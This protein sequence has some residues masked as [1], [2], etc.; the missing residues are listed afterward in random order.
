MV[1][2]YIARSCLWIC[3]L[4]I[5]ISLISIAGNCV[6]NFHIERRIL[7]NNASDVR[8]FIGLLLSI[9][10]K[11]WISMIMWVI[12]TISTMFCRSVWFRVC[13]CRLAQE[14][15]LWFMPG[16]LVSIVIS[17]NMVICR[18]CLL[19]WFACLSWSIDLSSWIYTE[20]V[21]TGLI[22]LIQFITLRVRQVITK[23][24]K[25]SAVIWSHF[26]CRY[27]HISLCIC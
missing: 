2:L 6:N 4:V 27:G 9:I 14:Y 3:S 11:Y 12:P 22:F 16:A 24:I 26:Y 13:N 8:R 7:H 25:I 21:L 15:T 19:V 10:Q 17:T 18:L 5:F 1:C 20:K 23:W